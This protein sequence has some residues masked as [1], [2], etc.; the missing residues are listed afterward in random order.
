MIEMLK[1]IDDIYM[2]AIKLSRYINQSNYFLINLTIY[3]ID[4]FTIYLSSIYSPIDQ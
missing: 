2:I 1:M 3:C 4:L